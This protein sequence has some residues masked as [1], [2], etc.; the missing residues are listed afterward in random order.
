MKQL[1]IPLSL[2]VSILVLLAIIFV[3]VTEMNDRDR[4]QQSTIDGLR[5]QNKKESDSLNQVLKVTQNLFSAREDSIVNA[6]EQTIKAH[7]VTKRENK[8]LKGI[9]FI[10]HTDSSRNKALTQLYKTYQ[11]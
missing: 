6:H 3:G 9:V 5:K 4:V 2:I 8:I 1:F 7:E 11:P 10:Q